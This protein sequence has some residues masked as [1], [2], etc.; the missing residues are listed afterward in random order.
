MSWFNARGR[1]DLVWL[2]QLERDTDVLHSLVEGAH[3]RASLAVID[4]RGE[5]AGDRDPPQFGRLGRGERI[6]RLRYTHLVRVEDVPV[7]VNV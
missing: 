6:H 5:I 2:G 7:P 1:L 3:Y 4:V